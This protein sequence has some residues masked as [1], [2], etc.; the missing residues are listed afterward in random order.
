MVSKRLRTKSIKE[1][2]KEKRTKKQKRGRGKG[3]G[4]VKQLVLEKKMSDEKIAKKEGEYFSEKDFPFIVKEDTDVYGLVDGKKKLLGRFRK[5]VIAKKLSK[6]A[7]VN[8]KEAAKKKH[9]NRG[10]AAGVIN[11]KDMAGYVKKENMVGDYKFRIKGYYSDT[12]GKFVNQSIGN[13]AQSNIIGYFDKPDRNPSAKNLPC[14]L[15][16]F[17]H[18]EMDKFKQVEPFLERIDKLFKR[19]IPEAHRKQY[20]RAHETD[21]VIKDT[22]FSTVTIN[23]NWRTALHKDAG[24]FEQGFG[25]LIVCEEGQYDG[26]CTGFPQYGVAFDV[27]DGDFL[28]MD[29]HEWHCNTKIRPKSKDHSRL[30]VVCYLRNNMLRCKGLKPDY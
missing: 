27:R 20:K 19:L 1:K 21:F 24:D 26:G 22:A 5:N 2:N 15:T 8:L 12:D 30:S 16:A 9:S 13:D 4:K 29:V 14:R 28:A 10:A 11:M 17:N 7:M 18:R 23:Y 3:K 6:V 25:N